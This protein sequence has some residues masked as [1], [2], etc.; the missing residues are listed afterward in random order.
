ETV[1]ERRGGISDD[2]V[3]RMVFHD[4]DK[5]VIEWRMRRRAHRTC[6][7][8]RK[9]EGHHHRARNPR[10]N[11]AVSKPPHPKQP[12]HVTRLPRSSSCDPDKHYK[13]YPPTAWR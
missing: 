2:L 7:K 10:D 9:R 13:L 1:D 8:R 11:R 5:H 6:R 3:V 12:H 4:D